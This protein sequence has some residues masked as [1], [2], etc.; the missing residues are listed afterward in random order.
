MG[1]LFLV[2]FFF[3]GCFFGDLF[4]SYLVDVFLTPCGWR[5]FSLSAELCVSFFRRVNSVAQ[6]VAK[7]YI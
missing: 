2:V 3:L 6:Y 1:L 4:F 5:Y 7:S